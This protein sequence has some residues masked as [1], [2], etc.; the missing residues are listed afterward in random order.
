MNRQ[1]HLQ[2][3][4]F[5]L[6]SILFSCI[7][8]QTATPPSAGDGT[9]GNPWQ[10]ANLD[11]LYW[12]SQSTGE[13]GSGKYFIQTANIDASASSS[14]DG[15]SGFSPIGNS[16]DKFNGN[17]NGNGYT[18]L[19]LYIDRGS[20]VGLFGFAQF[21]EI[22]NLG[23]SNVSI[24][25]SYRVG[26]LIGTAGASLTVSNCYSS[27]SVT[28]Q[29]YI[30]GLVGETN[31]SATIS[32]C[33]STCS[34][35]GT[36]RTGGFI[37]SNYNGTINN[38]FS[39]GDVNRLTG[40]SEELGGF[41]GVSGSDV[42]RYCY[43][44]GRVTYDNGSN[45][46]HNGFSGGT[47][48]SSGT[49][50]SNFFD[51][52]TSH[53]SS[54]AIGTTPKKT[55]ELQNAAT[56]TGTSSSWDFINNP[57]SDNNNDDI[58]GIN[59]TVNEGYPFLAWEGYSNYL[60]QPAA[61]DGS[62]GNPY[63]ITDL[64]DLYWVSQIKT[65]GKFFVQN[66]NIDASQTSTWCGGKG[67]VPIGGPWT[68]KFSGSYD[69]DGYNIDGLQIN[70]EQMDI[71]LFGNIDD[72]II[73]NLGV[74]NVNISGKSNTGAL[75]GNLQGSNAK[76][77]NCFSTGQVTG[78]YYVGGLLGNVNTLIVSNCYSTCVTS[79]Y[80]Y[81]GGLF[82]YSYAGNISNCYS[83]GNVS[84][85]G[86]SSTFLGG[87]AG[88][89]SDATIEYCYS[90]GSIEYSGSSNP[91]DKGFLGKSQG[92]KNFVSNFFDNESSQQSTDAEGAATP[93]T[94]SEMK[95]YTTFTSAAWDFV[96]EAANGNNDYWDADQN[97]TVNDGYMILAWQNGADNVLPVE[98]TTFTAS[99]AGNVVKL[100]WE[101]ATEVNNYGFNIERK[102][103]DGNWNKIGFVEG[104]GN[105]NSPKKYI[106]T[107]NNVNGGKYLYRLKQI[108]INGSSEYSKE[109]EV[110]INNV[111]K[112]FKLAQN[113]P[114]PFNPATI[115]EYSIPEVKTLQGKY[116]QVQ[117]KVYN[118]LGKE[119]ATLVNARQQAGNYKVSFDG[120]SLSSGVYYYKISAGSFT[121]IKR[122]IL[123][124]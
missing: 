9:S 121:K 65:D 15:G 21:G 86:G 96:N 99:I 74:I 11:N 109:L 98:L 20:T 62:S 66:M 31:G 48:G 29:G 72:G 40:N 116:Q 2:K 94:S 19:G 88:Y 3:I 91:T 102:P 41:C 106:F 37:G 101:T 8:A 6:V 80:N 69:G 54:D 7:T 18:I 108:D 53:Q 97:T 30:G 111:P 51:Y 55:Y 114:N 90:T 14:W 33:F 79:G 95:D 76:V 34:V 63:Q 93:K 28:G 24:S 84:R 49:Y 70:R 1:L 12:L 100:N 17:Y 113:Y 92:Q 43:S 4:I 27:G 122:M 13:W 67:F 42:I 117:L 85:R 23:L 35:S 61:G 10:I 5:L 38:C 22:K 16:T 56:Y 57:N 45:P 25:G 110:V 44:T 123:I 107:D 58:W 64:Q 115:I 39:R 68:F 71:G 105:S 59:P 73:K 89:S 119:V 124:K 75:G 50:T 103:E 26:A 87:F 83:R 120:K 36:A 60:E 118:I 81:T 46:I 82:G 78:S 52:N 112:K 47:Q 32:A 104:N 77:N